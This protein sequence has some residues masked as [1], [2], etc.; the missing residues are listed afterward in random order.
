MHAMM[1]VCV[2][3]CSRGVSAHKALS[4]RFTIPITLDKAD[5]LPRLCGTTGNM[6]RLQQRQ[7]DVGDPIEKVYAG[8][9][10]R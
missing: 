2:C 9:G 6:I 10:R 5:E 4:D 1:Q 3:K 8:Q 7:L